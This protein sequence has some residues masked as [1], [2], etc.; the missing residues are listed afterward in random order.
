MK[1]KMAGLKRTFATR[2][3]ADNRRREAETAGESG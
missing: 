2:N 3:T 1:E